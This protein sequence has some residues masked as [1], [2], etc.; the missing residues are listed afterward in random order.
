MKNTLP[1][2]QD[3]H[4]GM[5]IRQAVAR[6]RRSWVVCVGWIF[7]PLVVSHLVNHRLEKFP[8]MSGAR[9]ANSLTPSARTGKLVLWTL[10]LICTGVFA[11]VRETPHNLIRSRDKSVDDKEVCVFC[12][13]PVI[14]SGDISQGKVT[15]KPLWQQSLG[16]DFVYTIYD[17][18]GRLGLGKSSV[19]SQ[20]LACL[21]CHDSIQAF[22]VGRTS[23]DHPFG[24]VYR[25]ASPAA[26]QST[27]AVTS[28]ADAATP[29]RQAQHLT[30]LE[31]FRSASRGTVEGREIFWVSRNGVTTR[32]T[33]GD[34]PLYGRSDG[35]M[36]LLIP[37]IEC[38]SCH[39]PHAS[40]ATFL[41]VSAEGSQLCL[42]CHDK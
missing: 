25:G 38:S 9:A 39:D 24:V 33:R 32:R 41:R 20:S 6:Q 17:D 19:G 13:T 3:E 26:I 18:I 5:G 23:A 36:G 16:V 14:E 15:T 31:D 7:A 1:K 28:A 27:G 2:G 34:L 30:A 21:S 4:A 35:V 29:F 8:A 11:D 22:G 37:H 40:T 12:H 42:T 10:L